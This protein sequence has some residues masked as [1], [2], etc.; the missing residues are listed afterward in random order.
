MNYRLITK[1]LMAITL[2]VWII[3]DVVAL[4]K[5]VEATESEIILNLAQTFPG[6][7]FVFGVVT[8]HLF[9]PNKYHAGLWSLLLVIPA[10]A[11]FAWPMLS[12]D[13]WV[14]LLQR[15]P[16]ATVLGGIPVGHYGWPQKRKQ[17]AL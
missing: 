3:W 15:Y 2:I 7:G 16:I 5:G 9:I 11:L 13:S 14:L 10:A 4:T 12:Q 8:G 17:H 1:L 6:F